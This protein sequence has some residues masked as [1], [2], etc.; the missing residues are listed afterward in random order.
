MLDKNAHCG[1]CG[2]K[3]SSDLWPRYCNECKNTAW[4]NPLPVTVILLSLYN[5]RLE[6]E[7]V[8]VRRAI[9]PHIGELALPG[10]Y[11][12]FGETWQQ[13]ASREL[14]EETGIECRPN[15]FY[16]IEMVTAPS[17][18][19][20]LI[21]CTATMEKEKLGNLV[22]NFVPNTEV[23]EI[24]LSK[25]PIELAFPTHTE[26]MERHLFHHNRGFYG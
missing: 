20:L 25:K 10:G 24:V 2:H 7:L 8:L 12:D 23:S 19:N 1:F 16:F 22:Q 5:E 9:P 11:L 4:R 15:D 13:G 17:N 3:Y 21:F 6:R 14:R 26:M 18:S